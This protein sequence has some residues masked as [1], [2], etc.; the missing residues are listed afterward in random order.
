MNKMLMLYNPKSGSGRIRAV[1]ADLIEQF[2]GCGWNV[3]VHPTSRAL[4]AEEF[5]AANGRDYDLIVISGGDGILHESINGLARLGFDRPLGYLPAG[6][7]NDFA[8][9]HRIPMEPLRA[10][11]L[12]EK[13]QPVL[14]DIGRFNDEYFSYI[15]ACGVSTQVSYTTSQADKKRFGPLAYIVNGL[16]TVDFAHW[17]NNCVSMKVQW[18]DGEAEGDFLFASFSN[19]LYIGGSDSLTDDSASFT[20]GKLECLLIRRPMNLYELHLIASGILRRDFSSDFFVRSTSAWYEVN[21][22]PADWTLDGEFGGTTTHARIEA[23]SGK[24]SLVREPL[25]NTGK[26]FGASREEEENEIALAKRN[27]E[28]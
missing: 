10:A 6:T 13:Y 1:L 21:S 14:V 2:S 12:I 27:A 3:T 8:S 9:T 16:N 23:V 4:D 15:A 28:E 25:E 24:F 11:D 22:E 20:D 5:L 17:E 19:T 26:N 18:E 7:V